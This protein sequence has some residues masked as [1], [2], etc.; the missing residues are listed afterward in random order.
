MTGEVVWQRY[1]STQDTGLS[2]C[3]ELSWSLHV[4]HHD[5]VVVLATPAHV[6]FLIVTILVL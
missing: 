5:E 6:R 3:Q 1:L 2:T 4:L